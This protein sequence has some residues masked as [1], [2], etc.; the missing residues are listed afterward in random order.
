[1]NIHETTN[2]T[3]QIYSEVLYMTPIRHTVQVTVETPALVSFLSDPPD[4]LHR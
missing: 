2:H 4:K 3:E 1:M